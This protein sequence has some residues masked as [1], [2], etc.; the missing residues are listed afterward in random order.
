LLISNKGLETLQSLGIIE[1]PPSPS[2]TLPPLEQ[3]AISEEE[4]LHLQRELAKLRENK[5]IVKQEKGLKQD[6]DLQ[7]IEA[8][9]SSKRGRVEKVVI[10][11]TGDD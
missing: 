8:F 5:A 6:N 4:R 9:E 10:D 11:L 7:N 2:P 1:R 3:D